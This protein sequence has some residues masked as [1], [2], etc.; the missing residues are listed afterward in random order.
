MINGG[1]YFFEVGRYDG[2]RKRMKTCEPSE[3]KYLIMIYS[4]NNQSLSRVTFIFLCSVFMIFKCYGENDNIIK[5]FNSSNQYD[6]AKAASIIKSSAIKDSSHVLLL[7]N[8]LK[9]ANLSAAKCNIIQALVSYK[10]QAAIAV[11]TIVSLLNDKDQVVVANAIG[12]LGEIKEYPQI[13]V[14]ALIKV[15][16]ENVKHKV[17]IARALGNFGQHAQSSIPLLENYKKESDS[18]VANEASHAIDNIQ[19]RKN[20]D[21]SNSLLPLIVS[22]IVELPQHYKSFYIKTC[23]NKTQFSY[24]GKQ[25]G[26]MPSFIEYF[27][28]DRDV[29]KN[30]VLLVRQRDYEAK[31]LVEVIK[32]FLSRKVKIYEQNNIYSNLKYIEFVGI[33]PE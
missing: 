4:K 8:R 25:F 11:P 14:P 18:T 30:T 2:C 12:A 24:D 3:V 15:G 32:Y 17:I 23:D 10:D 21:A 13:C 1:L 19:G 22:G 7:V 9:K 27:E 26:N 20:N 33:L 29:T 6:W 31:K 28:Q 5:L 16:H